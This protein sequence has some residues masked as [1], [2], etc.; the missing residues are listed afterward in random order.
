[1]TKLGE[2]LVQQLPKFDNLQIRLAEA[3]EITPSRLTAVMKGIYTLD[4]RNCLM[5][6]KKAD[7]PPSDVLRA[8]GKGEIADLIEE[9]YGPTRE[10]TTSQRELLDRWER[11]EQEPD[12]LAAV[13]GLMAR[14]E[15]LHRLRLQGRAG[16]D[17]SSPQLR[18]RRAGDARRRR[19]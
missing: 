3:I 1:V 12:D 7:I 17:K 15:L 14:I 4:V 6:A 13:E 2:L 8:A 19:Q 5:F 16:V 10:L 18:G 9:L 11:L